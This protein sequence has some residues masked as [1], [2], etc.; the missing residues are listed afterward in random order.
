MLIS[1]V[2]FLYAVISFCFGKRS[3]DPQIKGCF[4]H[5]FA[6]CEIKINR[7]VVKMLQVTLFLVATV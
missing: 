6:L 4:L 7:M 3:F 5:I 2:F 1:P